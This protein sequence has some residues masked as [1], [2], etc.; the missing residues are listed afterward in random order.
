MILTNRQI[1]I[2]LFE[3]LKNSFFKKTVA[4]AFLLLFILLITAFSLIVTRFHYKLELSKQKD[5]IIEQA[6]LDEQWSQIVLEY[7]SLATPTSVEEFA[8]KENMSLPTKNEMEFLNI[9]KDATDE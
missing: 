6:H 3:S 1:R 5:L 4:L 9:K 7:S 2:R 8:D